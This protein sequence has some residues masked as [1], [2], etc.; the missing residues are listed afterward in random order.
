MRDERWERERERER[1]TC[2]HLLPFLTF[3]CLSVSLTESDPN[4]SFCKLG[5]LSPLNSFLL[6]CCCFLAYSFFSFHLIHSFCFSFCDQILLLWFIM[7]VCTVVTRSC[8]R[9]CCERRVAVNKQMVS[10][11]TF[12]SAFSYSF[13]CILA[14]VNS[15]LGVCSCSQERVTTVCCME[16]FASDV[17][18]PRKQEEEGRGKRMDEWMDG[19]NTQRSGSRDDAGGEGRHVRQHEHQE[20]E[21]GE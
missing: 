6:F 2:C 5:I 8:E 10:L 9:R 4:E 17:A 11:C 16:M 20:P 12:H 14:S 3:L 7:Y 1:E 13:L 15:S 18:S 21:Q 19:M